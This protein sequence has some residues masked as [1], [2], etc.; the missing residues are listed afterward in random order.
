LRGET[1]LHGNIEMMH[2]FQILDMFI[3]SYRYVLFK[4]QSICNEKYSVMFWQYILNVIY[5]EKIRSRRR[6]K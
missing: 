3:L 6:I 5:Y 1:P 2:F 4:R